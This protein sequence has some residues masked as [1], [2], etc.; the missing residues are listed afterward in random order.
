MQHSKAARE[1]RVVADRQS[2]KE[3]T[4]A[5]LNQAGAIVI[6]PPILRN[7]GKTVATPD[8]PLLARL[9]L[10]PQLLGSVIEPPP[11]MQPAPPIQAAIDGTAAHN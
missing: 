10:H 3:P 9:N 5:Q 7:E 8:P 11:A 2:S 6:A 1:T 4:A